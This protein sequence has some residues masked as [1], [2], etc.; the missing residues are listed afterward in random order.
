MA[1]QSLGC[2]SCARWHRGGVSVHPG[3]SGRV[4]MDA[5]TRPD[6]GLSAYM[7]AD[8]FG[9]RAAFKRARAYAAER[10]GSAPLVAPHARIAHAARA[11]GFARMMQSGLSDES[12][13]HA[14]LAS[15][16]S[17]SRT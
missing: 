8:Q 17:F 9:G 12:I 14:L 2:A 10:A 15:I 11:A 7:V 13:T 3:D 5:D 1:G 6:C 16:R 4:A